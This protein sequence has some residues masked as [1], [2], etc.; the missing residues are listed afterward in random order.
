[1]ATNANVIFLVYSFKNKFK[2]I[3]RYLIMNHNTTEEEKENISS[4]LS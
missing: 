3:I 2:L 1:V 4:M